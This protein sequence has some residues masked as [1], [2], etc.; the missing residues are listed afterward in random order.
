MFGTFVSMVVDGIPTQT[1]VRDGADVCRCMLV[2]D[3][4]GI[5]AG[6]DKKGWSGHVKTMASHQSLR[7]VVPSNF[8][9]SWSLSRKLGNFQPIHCHHQQ[10][11]RRIKC[12]CPRLNIHHHH[13]SVVLLRRLLLLLL[14]FIIRINNNTK[15]GLPNLHK[16][17]S[18]SLPTVSSK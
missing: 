1:T 8:F 16:K 13:L 7:S 18:C 6:H 10:H 5:R 3:E 12:G 17:S 4:R 15:A 14:L 11:R 9:F 2:C